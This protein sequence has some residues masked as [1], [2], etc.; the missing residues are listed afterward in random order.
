MLYE[1]ITSGDAIGAMAADHGQVGHSHMAGSLFPDQTHP[2][3]A[4]FVFGITLPDLIEEAAV[5]FK[6]DF[7]VAW[8]EAFKPE[9]R[10]CFH[11]LDCGLIDF[12]AIPFS[13]HINA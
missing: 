8:E 10:P 13:F 11:G 5:D 3:H 2:L 4:C 12:L 9:D 7:E 1:V 6:D